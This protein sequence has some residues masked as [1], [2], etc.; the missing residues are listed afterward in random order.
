MTTPSQGF[1]FER[2]SALAKQDPA[3]FEELRRQEVEAFI[4]TAPNAAQRQRLERLQWRIDRERERVKNPLSA[5]IRIYNM[6]WESVYRH[7]RAILALSEGR[8]VTPD[9]AEKAAVLTFERG[10]EGKQGQPVV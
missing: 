8:P 10:S 4:K 6:M 1:D 2:W 9:K 3:R 5:C 7:Q